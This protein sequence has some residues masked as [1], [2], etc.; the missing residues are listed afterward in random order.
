MFTECKRTVEILRLLCLLL[1]LLACRAINNDMPVPPA[2]MEAS[3]NGGTVV[4]RCVAMATDHTHISAEDRYCFEF[5]AGFTMQ[6]EQPGKPVFAGPALDDNLEP[7]RATLLVEVMPSPADASLQTVVDEYLTE[8]SPLPTPPIAIQ[9]TT[10]GGAPALQ[11]EVVPGREGS[12]DVWAIH[13]ARLY[14]LMFMPSVRDFPQAQAEVEQLFTTVMG[15]FT[16]LPLPPDMTAGSGS[17]VCPEVS[18]PALLFGRQPGSATS[19]ALMSIGGQSNCTITLHNEPFGNLIPAD[20]TLFYAVRDGT[21]NHMSIWR[22]GADGAQELAFT[23]TNVP[24]LLYPFIVSDDGSYIAYATVEPLATGDNS[25]LRSTLYVARAEGREVRQLAQHEDDE[26]RYLQPVRF[27]QQNEQ[28]YYSVAPLNYGGMW[29]GMYGR[30]DNLY[31][32]EVT[33]TQAQLIF[34]CPRGGLS[35]CIGD[36]AL[37]G[38]VFAYVNPNEGVVRVATMN[39]TVTTTVLPPG[40]DYVGFPTFGPTGELACLS[41]T[42]DVAPGPPAPLPGYVS[43]LAPPYTGEAEIWL[44]APGIIRIWEWSDPDHMILF[45]QGENLPLMDILQRDGTTQPLNDMPLGVLL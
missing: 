37:D 32:S 44:T 17:E 27:A 12:R 22:Y 7:L 3:S 31:R 20:G 4:A 6:E 23:R 43:V 13:D 2:P 29:N 33:G 8:F 11:L 28:L 9:E 24:N 10:L 5:P 36:V 35:L 41:A 19:V 42:L 38:S 34:D 1:V 30:Y 40:R 15:S 39:G 26:G 18:R 21:T 14:H 25:H 45:L 16:F